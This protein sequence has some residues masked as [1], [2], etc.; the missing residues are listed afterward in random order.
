MRAI[1][2]H[3]FGGPEVMKIEDVADPRPGP[4]QVLIRV[5]AV[6]VNPVE[7]YIRAGAYGKLPALPYTPGTDLSG[8]VEALGEGVRDLSVGDAVYTFGTVTGAYAELAVCDRGHV[9]PLPPGASF[10]AGAALG[11]AGATAW[12]A[13]FQRGVALPGEH[14]LVH[15]ASGGVGSMTVQLA[16]AAGLRVVG[17]AGT[18]DGLARVRALGA[19]LALDHRVDG[20]LDQGLAFTGSSGFDLI[21]EFLAN[22]NLARDMT[23]LAPR[24][25]I[26]VVGSRGPIE[27]DPRQLMTRDAS[28]AGMSLFNA[29]AAELRQVHAGLYA[30]LEAGTLKPFI[31]REHALADAAEAHRE[32]MR[33][34]SGGKLVLLP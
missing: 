22:V 31:G 17:T 9:Y 12:R 30:A 28:V 34:G 32:V 18:D 13:L 33:P 1:R 16:R 26:V 7:T 27:I 5:R 23:V 19:H 6:G 3:E 15:G 20:Y 8:T 10:A 21:I 24:G 11:V 29:T 4:G 25:R 14:L 2:V